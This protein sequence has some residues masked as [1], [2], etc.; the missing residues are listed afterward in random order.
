MQNVP[1]KKHAAHKGWRKWLLLAAIAL[2]AMA[3]CLLIFART[4]APLPEMPIEEEEEITLWS[5][6]SDAIT[7]IR[8]ALR[9]EEAWSAVQPTSGTLVLEGEDSF[10]LDEATAE[11]LLSGLKSITAEVLSDDWHGTEEEWAAFGLDNPESVVTVE[12]TNGSSYTLRIGNAP[13]YENS[14]QYAQLDG[15]SRL[16]S[17]SRGVAEECYVTRGSLH[18]FEQLTIHADRLDEITLLNAQGEITQQWRLSSDITNADAQERWYVSIPVRYPADATAM[19]TLRKSAAAIRLG[20][21]IADATAAHIARYGLDTPRAV[22]RLHQAAGTIGVVGTSGAYGT[23]DYPESTITL[24]IGE[25]ESDAVDYVLYDGGIY[26]CSA[27][28]LRGVMNADWQ[29]TVT[30]YPLLTALGN[31]SSL[32]RET[33]SGTDTWVI[34]RTEQVAEN[35]ELATDEDGNPLYDI[36]LTKNGEA[37]DYTAFSAAY[38]QLMVATVSGRLPEGWTSED[39]PH[40]TWTFVDIDGTAHTVA[41]TRYDAMHDAVSVDGTALFYLIQGGFTLGTL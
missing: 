12:F 33:A 14:W 31:L 23:T 7:R 38:E 29:E 8:I 17:V 32:T 25:Q 1:K 18:R 21:Y 20:E 13:Q 6:D 9:G 30:R 5:V 3:A 10:T 40:T 41:L 24:V 19:T 4:P 28:L 37:A 26:R 15:D 22:I 11:S 36:T 34:T 39:A 27:L 16:L 35:N 2:V